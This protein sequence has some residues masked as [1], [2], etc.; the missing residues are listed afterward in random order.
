MQVEEIM[1]FDDYWSDDRFNHKK[2]KTNGSLAQMYGDNF[3]H[4]DVKSKEWIQEPSAHSVI[5]KSKH[6]QR[7]TSANKVLISSN[8]YYLGDEA[9]LIPEKYHEICKAGPGMKY[10]GLN[11]VGPIFIKWVQSQVKKGITG[12]PINWSEYLPQHNQTKLNL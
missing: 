8:F 3:Y 5:S 12:D 7:D 11:E 9:I 2:P 4:I 1:S 6:I 10:K